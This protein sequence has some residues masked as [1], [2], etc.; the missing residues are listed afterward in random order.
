MIATVNDNVFNGF[1]QSAH[2]GDKGGIGYLY[3][4]VFPITIK[5]SIIL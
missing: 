3:C 2:G 5:P 4:D 1:E